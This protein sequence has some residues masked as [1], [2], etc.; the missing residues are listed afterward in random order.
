[1]TL[2]QRSNGRARSRPSGRGTVIRLILGVVLL[3]LAFLLGIAVS[4]AL[5]ERPEP[6]A[7]VTS[8]RTLTPRPQEPPPRTVTVTVT[9]P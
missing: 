9:E 6:G 7:N 8:V 1:V 4:R 2:L 5:D 3:V